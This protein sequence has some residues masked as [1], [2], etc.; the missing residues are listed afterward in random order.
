MCSIRHCRIRLLENCGSYKMKLVLLG[1]TDKDGQAWMYTPGRRF[2]VKVHDREIGGEIIRRVN[3]HERLVKALR[4]L[5]DWGREHTSPTDA[6]S[7]HDLLVAAQDVL[8][9]VP[10]VEFSRMTEYT[11]IEKE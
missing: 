5:T 10:D 3:N 7:P 9:E 1:V 4:D 2:Q 6:N 8:N 11:P